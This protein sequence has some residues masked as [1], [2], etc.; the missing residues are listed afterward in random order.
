M[1]YRKIEGGK[2]SC[3]KIDTILC[4]NKSRK[5]EAQRRREKEEIRQTQTWRPKA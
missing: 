1:K 4:E 2:K 5:R 3:V